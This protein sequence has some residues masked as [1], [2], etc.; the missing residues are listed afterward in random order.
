MHGQI[1]IPKETVDNAKISIFECFKIQLSGF[2]H[3]RFAGW[4]A[5]VFK[6]G[7]YYFMWAEHNEIPSDK[8]LLI[9]KR[10]GYIIYKNI[11]Q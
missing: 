10:E 11:E 9:L 5:Y 7:I 8:M 6:D 4:Y 2:I 3:P 1:A